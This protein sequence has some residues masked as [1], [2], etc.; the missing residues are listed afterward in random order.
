ME[1]GPQM[2]INVEHQ[3]YQETTKSHGSQSTS[4]TT[5]THQVPSYPIGVLSR[6]QG[7]WEPGDVILMLKSDSG[8]IPHEVKNLQSS[9][10]PLAVKRQRSP[11]GAKVL[12][13]STPKFLN[14][15]HGNHRRPREGMGTPKNS[16]LERP[17]FHDFA[18]YAIFEPMAGNVNGFNCILSTSG[19]WHCT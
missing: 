19:K 12:S 15:V 16:T 7:H 6:F 13:K 18:N 1:I 14:R 5:T 4:M 9:M 2:M 11:G 10:I 8:S 3:L 17:A